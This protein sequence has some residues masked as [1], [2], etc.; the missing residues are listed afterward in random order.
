MMIENPFVFGRAAE[1]SYF[2]DR[3]EDASLPAFCD[4]DSE[5][6]LSQHSL[7]WSTCFR[8]AIQE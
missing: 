4:L 6:S 1:G 3:I 8:S 2:T 7:Y 5:T